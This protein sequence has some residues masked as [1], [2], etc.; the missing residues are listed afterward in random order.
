[1]MGLIMLAIIVVGGYYV[2]PVVFSIIF[3]IGAMLAPIA[4]III[5]VGFFYLLITCI[6]SKK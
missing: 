3:A 5:V 1:M 4:G 6:F 2:L